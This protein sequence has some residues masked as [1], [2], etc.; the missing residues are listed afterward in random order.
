MGI[1]RDF[2]YYSKSDKRAIL[3]LVSIAVAV[4]AVMILMRFSK[5]DESQSQDNDGGS[6]MQEQ[7]AETEEVLVTDK[8]EREIP[9][10]TIFDY[11]DEEGYEVDAD[12]AD[13]P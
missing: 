1:W 9:A 5:P 3:M 4:F 10:D 8:E 13:V 6:V 11:H 7:N 12:E 2:F